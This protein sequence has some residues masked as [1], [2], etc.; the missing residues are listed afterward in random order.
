MALD[1]PELSTSHQDHYKVQPDSHSSSTQIFRPL[2]SLPNRLGLHRLKLSQMSHHLP[3]HELVLF[4]RATRPLY[5]MTRLVIE[6][7]TRESPP[8]KLARKLIL[9]LGDKLIP[10]KKSIALSLAGT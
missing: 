6:I 9:R 5:M 2:N 8:A 10:F 3:V 4:R 7:Y 1:P